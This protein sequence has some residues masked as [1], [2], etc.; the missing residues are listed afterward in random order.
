[1]KW[2]SYVLFVLYLVP[3]TLFAED[4]T[5]RTEITIY[6][7]VSF[8]KVKNESTISCV[9]CARFLPP[10]ANLIPPFQQKISFDGGILIGFKA[11]F[12]LN[13]HFEV[14]GNFS[15]APNQHLT[16]EAIFVCPPNIV[17]PLQGDAGTADIFPLFVN[18]TH[19]V[20]YYYDGNFVYNFPFKSATPFATFGV[21]GISTSLD[22]QTNTDLA[23]NFGG[24]VKF[25]FHTLGFRVEANDHVIPDHF[26]S[27]NTEHDFQVQY[28]LLFRL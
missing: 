23:I 20:S 5:G 7:G 18:R 8:L 6:S 26:L 16:S 19:A 24:G 27:G 22:Q 15:I 28:G 10:V 14:E 3:L 17:C 1:M 9:V 25:R 4:Q 21:G 12:Y 2:T 11:G 13:D